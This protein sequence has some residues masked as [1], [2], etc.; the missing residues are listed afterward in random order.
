[1][2]GAV[3]T[4]TLSRS[5]RPT[6]KGNVAKSGRHARA[7]RALFLPGSIFKNI[8]RF[9]KRE[10]KDTPALASAPASGLPPFSL[11]LTMPRLI[12]GIL[13]LL[14]LL[15]WAFFLGVLMGRSPEGALP[16]VFMHDENSASA[17]AS[18]PAELPAPETALSEKTSS[19]LL[20]EEL[21]FLNNINHKN[22]SPDLLTTTPLPTDIPQ[23]TE[24]QRKT[25][26]TS[27]RS[28]SSPSLAPVTAPSVQAAAKAAAPASSSSKYEYVYQVAASPDRKS[29]LSLKEKLQRNGYAAALEHTEKKGKPLYRVL[30]TFQATPEEMRERL[31]QLA[32]LNIK[33]SFLRARKAL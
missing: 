8:F 1:M 4:G 11:T 13:G 31:S 18:S 33:D 5:G 32:K 2:G 27:A 3:S 15:V 20:P 6:A 12:G 26:E 10:K 14:L 29:I 25:T 28:F 17:E 19:V 23:L 21:H 24:S 30:V 22:T 7:N 9:R 16:L